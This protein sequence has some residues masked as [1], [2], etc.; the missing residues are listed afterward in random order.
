M[1]TVKTFF[2]SF[3]LSLIVGLAILGSVDV[4]L[5]DRSTETDTPKAGVPMR[6]VSVEDSKTLLLCIDSRQPYFFLLKFSAIENRV[7]IAA[8]SPSFEIDN[9]SLDE[10][11]RKAGAMQC[12]MDIEERYGIN[13]D[14][15]LQCTWQQLGQMINGMRDIEIDSLGE[16]LPSGIKNYLF[17]GADMLD[18]KSLVNA[19]SNFFV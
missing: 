3:I 1:R 9:E 15:Y 14:Y 12:L 11:F 4:L 10:K 17:K 19:V 13:I 8:I 7:G 18:V 5:P 16:N 2:Y 6:Q